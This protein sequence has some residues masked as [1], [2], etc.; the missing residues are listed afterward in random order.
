M[1]YYSNKKSETEQ[2]FALKTLTNSLLDE[3]IKT[4]FISQK[5]LPDWLTKLLAHINEN[6]HEDISVEEL[7][8]NAPYSYSRL[9]R[10]FKSYMGKTITEYITTY[11]MEEAIVL[12]QSTNK[13][14]LDISLMLQYKSISHF[15]RTFKN[16]CGY[17]PLQIRKRVK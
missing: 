16:Y 14:I 8:K 5:I 4:N 13:S 7:T 12:L 17:T 10:I 2:I 6:I 3:I 11:K 1:N 9:S 15:N